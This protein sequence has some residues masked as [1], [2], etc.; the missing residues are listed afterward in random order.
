MR[1]R[2][3]Y[4]ITQ[5][6]QRHTCIAKFIVS[7]VSSR[8]ISQSEQH[9]HSMNQLGTR[10]KKRS[11]RPPISEIYKSSLN[12]PTRTRNKK[13]SYLVKSVVSAM[14]KP[15]HHNMKLNQ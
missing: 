8:I 5:N 7:V 1:T 13:T 15:N 4:F 6:I 3:S 12:E 14:I 9:V 10:Q 2:N 11:T